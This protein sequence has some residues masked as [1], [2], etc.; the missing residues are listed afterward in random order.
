[1]K[2]LIYQVKV[3]NPPPFYDICI[4][5]VKKYCEKYNIH[6]LVQTEPILKIKPYNSKRPR[7]KLGYLPVFEKENAFNYF[8]DYDA[9]AIIDS[10]I[11]IRDISPNLFEQLNDNTVFAG[12]RER[13]MPLTPAYITKIKKF[14]RAQYG[15]VRSVMN[16]WHPNYGY[17]FY[18]MGMMLCSNKMKEYLNGET[19][20]QFIR[21][22]EFEPMVNG[23]GDYRWS[24]DQTLL[25][26]WIQKNKITTQNLDW[27]WNALVKGVRDDK[28]SEAYFL[29]FFLANNLPKKGA[30]IPELIK[31]LSKLKRIKGHG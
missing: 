13:D 20:E 16:K 2:T 26:Y 19:P 27:K 12:V 25:N 8:D 18:N 31:D 5:S 14:S 9:I 23:E 24:T 15:K 3:G 10:D 21:R 6:H 17:S 30:E 1:M 29:H 4:D 11:Y 22:K 28:L 7:L